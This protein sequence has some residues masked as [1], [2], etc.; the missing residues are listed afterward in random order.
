[1]KNA[2]KIHTTTA[3]EI[4]AAV[5]AAGVS[6]TKLRECSICGTKLFY[7]FDQ[8]V[9]RNSDEKGVFFTSECECTSFGVAP[10]PRTWEDIAFLINLQ[11]TTE[12]YNKA[13]QLFF[14]DPI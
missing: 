14:L 6:S 5:I 3:E 4:K 13:R 7:S 12:N 11:I 1:M 9:I 10:Q 2:Q 8:E